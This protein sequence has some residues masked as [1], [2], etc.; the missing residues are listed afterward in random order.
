MS[1]FKTFHRGS[2]WCHPESRWRRPG[3]LVPGLRTALLSHFRSSASSVGVLNYSYDPNSPSFTGS[4][5]TRS[6]TKGLCFWEAGKAQL[7]LQFSTVIPA[8][9]PLACKAAK[10]YGV[11]MDACMCFTDARI[12]RNNGTRISRFHTST[13]DR[14]HLHRLTSANAEI[15][16]SLGSLI[17]PL[18]V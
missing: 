10:R 18:S 6:E 3:W 15:R 13:H 11:T 7:V 5:S 4:A 16:L 12:T 17:T 1:R 8:S 14:S 2:C 9:Y